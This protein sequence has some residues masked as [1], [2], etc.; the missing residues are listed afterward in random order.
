MNQ[1]MQGSKEIRHE[2]GEL[3]QRV[4]LLEMGF[5]G[6]KRMLVRHKTA[7][8]LNEDRRGVQ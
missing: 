8:Q 1:W 3:D 2:N 5:Q 7:P 6:T 4:P